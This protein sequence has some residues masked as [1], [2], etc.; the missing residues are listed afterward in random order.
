MLRYRIAPDP[1]G[2]YV[3]IAASCWAMPVS[4]TYSTRAEAQDTADWLNRLRERQW[5]DDPKNLCLL[6]LESASTATQ[7]G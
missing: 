7:S 6:P 4:E 2:H 3:V 1:A 5:P